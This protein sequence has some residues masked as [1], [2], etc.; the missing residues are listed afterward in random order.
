VVGIQCSRCNFENPPGF[1][2]CGE[3]ASPLIEEPPERTSPLAEEPER[4]QLTVVFCDLVGSTKLSEQ[5]DPE[6]FHLILRSY[7]ALCDDVV[8]EFDGFIAQYLGDG[9]LIYFGYPAAQEDGA[10][11]A[12]HVALRIVEDLNSINAKLEQR[13]EVIRSMPLRV[14]IGVHTG[15]V[16]I[17]DVGGR[18]RREHLAVGD[19]PNVA[20]RLQAFAKPNEIII[21]GSTNGLIEGFFDCE[22]IGLNRFG[23]ISSEV[24]LFKVVGK[25]EFKSR[26][27]VIAAK[28]L[29]PR[30]ARDEELDRLERG[31]EKAAKELGQVVL[32]TGEAGIGKSRL[33]W[34]LRNKISGRDHRRL[35]GQCLPYYQTSALYPLTDL[36]GRLINLSRRDTDD[37]KIGK[38][39]KFLDEYDFSLDESIPHFSSFLSIQP[40]E[41]YPPIKTSPQKQ[42]EKTLGL[43]IELLVRISERKPVLFVIEDLHWVDASTLEFLDMFIDGCSSLRIYAVLTYRPEFKERW[44]K[45]PNV[46]MISLSRLGDIHAEEMINKL[47]EG[48]RF[49][50][51]VIE[52]LISRTDGIPLFVEEMTRGAM[53][54]GILGDREELLKTIGIPP[55]LHDSLMARIDRLSEAKDVL[56]LASVMGSGFSYDLISEASSLDQYSLR[57][58]LTALVEADLL[59]HTDGDSESDYEFKHAL[60]RDAAYD[61]LLKSKRREYHRLIAEALEERLRDSIDTRPELIAHH[62]TE[63]GLKEKAIPYWH[64]AGKQAIARSANVEAIEHLRKGIGLVKTLQESPERSRTELDLQIALSDPLIMQHGWGSKELEGVYDRARELCDLIGDKRTT[65]SVLRGQWSFNAV[66]GRLNTAKEIGREFESIVKTIQDQFWTLESHTISGVNAVYTGE[67]LEASKY[68]E[69]GLPIY[70]R[71]TEDKKQDDL[72]FDT[73]ILFMSMLGS[74]NPMFLGYRDKGK[75]N[76]YRLIDLTR[77]SVNSYALSFS[78]LSLATLSLF[79]GDVDVVMEYTDRALDIAEENGYAWLISVSLITKGWAISKLKNP[80]KGIELIKRGLNEYESTGAVLDMPSRTS[81]L[82]ECYLQLGETEEAI[83]ILDKALEYVNDNDDR[84]CEAEIYRLKGESLLQLDRS[85]SAPAE[86]CFLKSIEI[87]RK[88][89]AKFWELKA[90]TNLSRLWKSQGKKVQART[91]LTGVYDWFTEGFDSKD[92]KDAGALIKELS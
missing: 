9:V 18:Q 23:G 13:F 25:R 33:I 69:K 84:S 67:F 92:L 76:A 65:L 49:P 85:N 74:A 64:Q 16:V 90:A 53:E 39:E 5:L 27:E 20:A 89:S 51:G 62:Y 15:S 50:D 54:A 4:R 34:E 48:K 42:R 12:I 35:E 37:E 22:S 29:T 66:R 81:F 83:K 80:Q 71:I 24:V 79:Y 59:Y 61:S 86:Q 73:L 6:E 8:T 40:P 3:C 41:T 43:L 2:F 19:T 55:T 30:V 1:K 87:A 26:F 52:K 11:R 91:L 58:D 28:R 14:R 75:E 45:K 7:Q 32:L 72:R 10:Q 88:R 77:H 57:R 68:F 70:N 56:Q 60:I 46:E 82:A 17:G 78:Y 63:A 21:S 36:M 31:W 44:S 38:L 47:S